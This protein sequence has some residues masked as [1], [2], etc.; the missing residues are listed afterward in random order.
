MY[1]VTWYRLENAMNK[2][3]ASPKRNS[4]TKK[5]GLAKLNSAAISDGWNVTSTWQQQ[6]KNNF[7]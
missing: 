1:L 4:K 3:I 6:Q 5:E 2:L 7:V